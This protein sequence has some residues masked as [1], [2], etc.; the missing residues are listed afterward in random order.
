MKL[1]AIKFGLA[2][3]ISIAILWIACSVLVWLLPSM[4]MNMTGHMIHGDWSS[5]GWHLSAG[6]VLIGLIVWS[7]TAGICGWLLAAFYTR[8]V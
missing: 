3:A 7:I 1:N 2:S 4:M 5:M 8:S 6:G